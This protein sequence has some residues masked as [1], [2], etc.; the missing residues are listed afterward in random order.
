MV[1]ISDVRIS[2][3]MIMACAS[4]EKYINSNN[5]SLS[6][7]G[8]IK[9]SDET[10]K[11]VEE[12]FMLLTATWDYQ[13]DNTMIVQ[14]M[15]IY[16]KYYNN[17]CINLFD[18]AVN[19]NKQIRRNTVIAYTK[20]KIRTDIEIKLP[21]NLL[22]YGSKVVI[23]GVNDIGFKLRLLFEISN[24]CNVVGWVG[25][26]E[27]LKYSEL[28][29]NVF[30][31]KN[32]E[33]DYVIV[34]AHN[35]DEYITIKDNLIANK[36]AEGRQIICSAN[37]RNAFDISRI[38]TRNKFLF[39]YEKL[40]HDSK[41]CIFGAGMVGKEI[42]AT[43]KATEYCEITAWVDNNYKHIEGEAVSAPNLLTEAVYDYVIIAVNDEHVFT[44]IKKQLR[45]EYNI[46]DNIIG[47]IKL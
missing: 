15:N 11:N 39:P 41:V 35:N 38:P 10:R 7:I 44:E 37:R 47:P 19:Q 3:K 26:D 31:L 6:N 17:N 9:I 29:H 1:L 42:Y 30:T 46:V 2:T 36:L 28:M 8:A 20:S 45:D 34:A 18:I 33:F 32:L 23:Y 40:P 25:N 5:R 43:I 16:D 12:L 14:Y 24:Y 22:P 13:L 27:E 4:G 21:Y